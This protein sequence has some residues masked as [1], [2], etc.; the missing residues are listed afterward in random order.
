MELLELNES[1]IVE[2]EMQEE[3]SSD[4]FITANTRLINYNELRNKCAIP[5]FAK[6][7]ESTIS[8]PEFI[9]A[10]RSEVRKFF[11]DKKVLEPCIRVSHPIKGRVPEAMGKPAN[12]LAENEKTV[13]FERMG[14]V[15]DIPELKE[16]V[17]G[18]TL[19]LTVGG[20]RA[21][22][23]ENLHSR[24]S[25][26]RF[27][28][29]IGF[30]NRICTNLCI[31]TD[32][33]SADIRV[34]TVSELKDYVTQLITGF[35]A[36]RQLSM[37]RTLSAHSIS[38]SQFAKLIGKARMHQYLPAKMKQEIPSIHLGDSQVNAVVKDYYQDDSFC[39][40]DRGNINLWNLYNLFTS[41]VKT[42]Y[43]DTFLDRN[44]GSTE[45]I[46]QMAESIRNRKEFWYL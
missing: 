5:V 14:F 17:N 7:N 26:E 2:V 39:R 44:V 45:F 10:V 28:V 27:K 33:Y 43:L 40:D 37:L 12:M 38:E 30:K 36:D 6:D 23:T 15:M 11:N 22:N 13:Y 32:G 41:A 31:F 19:S 21:Y 35:N 24:K 1:P 46:S 3:I 20:V 34:R 42:S 4:Q 25:E 29:F 18:N 9:G 8:H 16:T